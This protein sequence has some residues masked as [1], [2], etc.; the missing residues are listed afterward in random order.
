MKDYVMKSAN[1]AQKNR[2]EFHLLSGQIPI[3]I[4]NKLP[5]HIDLKSI[6][7]TL[8]KNIP[9]SII[10]MIE[11]IY[12]GDFKELEERN[13]QAMF[14]DGVIYLSS[15]NN[16]SD[17]SDE[18]IAKDICHELAHAVESNMGSDIYAD[19]RIEAEYDGKKRKL[20]SLLTFE[21]YH[22]PRELFFD[23]NLIGDLDAFL[24]GEIGYDKLFPII[25]GLF[26]SPYSITSIRE[27][28]AN[29]MEDYLLGDSSYVKQISPI[30]YKKLDELFNKVNF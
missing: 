13:I 22:F 14:K 3:Y 17:V 30:L 16:V 28:F 1:K 6:I 21:G 7:E 2:N 24:Y 25:S 8:E 29:G 20:V 9:S 19:G 27:Y 15:F 4:I 23:E 10:N 26:M 12:I 5:K 11:G 18:I